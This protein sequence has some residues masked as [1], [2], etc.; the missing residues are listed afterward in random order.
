MWFEKGINNPD[1]DFHDLQQL[2]VDAA[3]E[4]DI[5]IEV[6]SF[7]GESLHCLIDKI[8]LSKKKINLFSV[9]H[10]DIKKMCR[11][12]IKCVSP[13]EYGH[14]LDRIMHNGKTPNEWISNFGEKCMLI[15]FFS[16]LEEAN[17]KEYV[18]GTL[19]GNSWEIA[20]VFKDDSVFF[21]F[22]DAGHSYEAICRDLEAW[23]PKIKENGI[24]CGHDWF[25]GEQI[26]T[27]VK[28]FSIKNKLS[29]YATTS[30]WVLKKE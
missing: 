23:F 19:I 18:T 29:I 2:A 16:K 6:G 15:E 30:S 26:R 5:F 28:E 11:E 22:I 25:S 7:I 24:F 1:C 10:F 13:K 3:K 4:E 9:D 17:K 21:C 12:N 27:A 20:K 14:P 8:I